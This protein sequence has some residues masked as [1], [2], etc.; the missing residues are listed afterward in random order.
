MILLVDT[1]LI[2]KPP[3][4]LFNPLALIAPH[5]PQLRPIMSRK[6]NAN[7]LLIE[8]ENAAGI[9]NVT[10]GGLFIGG[11]EETNGGHYKGA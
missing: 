11:P 3:A 6:M 7:Y 1:A 2:P 9:V 10:Y 4:P 5:L 8:A